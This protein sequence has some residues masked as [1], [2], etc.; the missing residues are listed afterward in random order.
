M[1]V[2]SIISGI[3]LGK[4]QSDS[5]KNIFL[6]NVSILK[7]SLLNNKANNILSHIII[8]SILL[9]TNSFILTYILSIIYLF[10]NGLS[11]GL[12]IYLLT[13]SFGIKGLLFSIIYN[14]VFKLL[15]I[16]LLC[17]FLLKGFLIS[18]QII[19]YFFYNKLSLKKYIK[20]NYLVSLSIITFIF[21]LD[22]IYHFNSSN[23]VNHLLSICGL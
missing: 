19:Y 2:I 22:I 18:K 11:I 8:L 9:I 17:F 3:L 20:K 10:Y 23:I 6:D 14:I 5:F 1:L 12:S 4:L 15:F 7:N 21:I 16:I 13:I